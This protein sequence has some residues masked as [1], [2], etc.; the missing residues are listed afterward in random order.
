MSTSREELKPCQYCG[1]P[2]GTKVGPPALAR[3][4]TPECEGTKLAADTFEKWN[5]LA[6]TPKAGVDREVLIIEACAKFLEREYPD[7]VNTNA[8]CASIRSL[9]L[10][11][12]L[13]GVDQQETQTTK[14]SPGRAEDSASETT[15]GAIYAAVS[16]NSTS[17]E[18]RAELDALINAKISKAMYG[19]SPIYY[20]RSILRQME[21]LRDFVGSCEVLTPSIGS[22][23][24]ADNIDWLDCFLDEHERAVAETGSRDSSGSTPPAVLSAPNEQSGKQLSPA[25]PANLHPR[26]LDMVQRFSVALAK[27]LRLAEEKYGFGD[28]W[29]D[30]HWE[31]ECR[32]HLYSHLEKGDPRDVAAYCAFMWHHGW[33]TAQPP[34]PETDAPAPDNAGLVSG[35][36]R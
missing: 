16:R 33:I 7:N 24:L 10:P 18:E 32:A 11:S 35:G 14:P 29:A 5:A 2:P 30:D 19:G 6:A 26:T 9:A 25:W 27:K 22:E 3:C 13:G 23:V 17:P 20:L 21:G 8:F 34:F 4:V 31:Q 36:G 28:G 1:K 12:V 15:D